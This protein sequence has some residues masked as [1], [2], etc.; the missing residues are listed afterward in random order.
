MTEDLSYYHPSLQA[1]IT[2]IKGVHSKLSKQLQRMSI[3]TVMDFVQCL[4]RSYDDRRQLPKIAALK[5]DVVQTCVG[6]LTRISEDRM[7]SKKHLLKAILRDSTGEVELIWFNQPFL[8]KVLKPNQKV[9]VKGYV[10]HNGFSHQTQLTVTETE[11]LKTF[12]SEK[13]A[14]GLILP[15]YPL[16][17]GLYQSQMRTI[18]R[19]VYTKLTYLKDHLT[20]TLCSRF[21]LMSLINAYQIMHFPES[22]A[23]FYQAKKRLVVDEL[24]FLT[25][26]YLMKRQLSE[27]TMS[28]RPFLPSSERATRYISS[29]P[30]TLTNAQKRV[31]EDVFSDLSRTKSMNR[32]VQ[33]DVGAG[34][35]DV[36]IISMLRA[37]DSG[38]SAVF[39][40]PTEILAEQHFIKCREQLRSLDVEVLLLKGKMRKAEKQ[41]VLDRL[42][43]ETPKIVVGTHAI[44]QDTVQISSLG[45][46]VVDEQHRFGVF[47]RLRLQKKGQS[48]HALYMTATP[49]P[50]T[51]S[52]SLYGDLDKSIIDELPSGRLPPKTYVVPAKKREDVYSFCLLELQKGR[53]VFIVYPLVE[54]SEKIDLEAAVS[55]YESLQKGVFN[56]YSLGLIHGKMPPKEK[57]SIM[58]A[59]KDGAHQLLVAT[60]VIEVG[61]DVPNAS[62]MVIMHAERYGL[63]QLHQLRGRI[64]RGQGSSTCFLLASPKSPESRKRLKAMMDTS[65]GFQ[66]A[67][68]DLQIRGAGDM[69]GT[70]QSGAD[71][72][73]LASLT[74]NESELIL[75]KSMAESIL[76]E[77]PLL[78]QCDYKGIRDKLMSQYRWCFEGQLN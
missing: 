5:Y 67:E 64:G 61:I 33:G 24:F 47:Q 30:Y 35:T 70:R 73:S 44:I 6:K 62:V 28:A 9:L 18:A 36:A 32:L 10:S 22:E 76:S 51:L 26:P 11:I 13:N 16:V 54:D 42:K 58:K 55:G 49:I 48:P 56:Q 74:D 57:Q 75:A 63:S 59:F 77:D 21:E 1:P 34:K 46:I 65:D 29:L 40:A 7:V 8:K 12:Q 71:S 17:S 60:T 69:L 14:I 19:Q 66:L 68:L 27:A 45:L 39:L 53:Q 20:A 3:S 41:S 78:T 2:T 15:V 52:L 25:L 50:R 43:E 31:L 23:L 37:I 38:C 4:P 72:L